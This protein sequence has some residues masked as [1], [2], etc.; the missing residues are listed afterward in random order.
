MATA[1][2]KKVGDFL[3]VG[4]AVGF[5]EGRAVG[6]GVGISDGLG[7]GIDEG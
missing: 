1:V 5:D 6:L 4:F 3:V 2:G 7:V